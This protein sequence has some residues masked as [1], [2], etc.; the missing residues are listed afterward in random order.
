MG[1]PSLLSKIPHD[2]ALTSDFSNIEECA[3]VVRAILSR[4][5][6]NHATF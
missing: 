1:V 5:Q 4:F 2:I 3:I 6:I